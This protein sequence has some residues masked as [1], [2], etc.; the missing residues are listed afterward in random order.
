[1]S[2]YA[3]RLEPGQGEGVQGEAGER[4]GQAVEHEAWDPAEWDVYC[5]QWAS[6]EVDRERALEDHTR[7]DGDEETTEIDAEGEGVQ[8]E[9]PEGQRGE[10]REELQ[11]DEDWEPGTWHP[12]LS[13]PELWEVDPWELAFEGAQATPFEEPDLL[14]EWQTDVEGEQA[15]PS[16]GS[17][18]RQDQHEND[19]LVSWAVLTSEGGNNTG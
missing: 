9:D 3:L 4:E 13:A 19:M 11:N 15:M 7:E 6:K 10:E 2:E 12:D 17:G 8:E 18:T 5:E 1:M 16:E 14:Y